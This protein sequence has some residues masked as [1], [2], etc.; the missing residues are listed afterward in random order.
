MKRTSP[1]PEKVSFWDLL[2]PQLAEWLSHPRN[3]HKSLATLTGCTPYLLRRIR[4]GHT[5][6]FYLALRLLTVLRID[7]SRFV[8][9]AQDFEELEK[10][11]EAVELIKTSR[12]ALVRTTVVDL[13]RTAP[14]FG[15]VAALIAQAITQDNLENRWPVG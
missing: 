13:L 2:N 12:P 3:N 14:R 15:D 7:I 1:P 11:L 5:P 10:D 9:A 6:D 8:E 4:R